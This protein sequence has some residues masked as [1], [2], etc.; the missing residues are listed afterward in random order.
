[1][2]IT[3]INL[4][5]NLSDQLQTYTP[6]K[7]HEA[8]MHEQFKVFVSTYKN[9][10]DRSLL[11]G[12]VTASALVADPLKRKVLLLHH[13]KL[14]RWLQPGGHCDGNPDTLEVAKTEVLEET[15]LEILTAESLVFDLDIHVI[16]E[17]KGIPEHLHYDVRYLF[18]A[19]SDLPLIQNHE[20]NALKWVSSDE[21]EILTSEES[22]VRMIRKLNSRKDI[23]GK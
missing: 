7:G 16:P 3:I 21:V 4:S 14:D 17:R 6:E 5:M 12:H 1:M 8:V 22:I 20:T 2:G 18:L 23:F 19:D 15:G 9:C 13:K 11:I 10:F